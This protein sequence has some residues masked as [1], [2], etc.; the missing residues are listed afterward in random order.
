MKTLWSA[1][2]HGE[3]WSTTEFYFRLEELGRKDE[4]KKWIEVSLDEGEIFNWTAYDLGEMDVDDY[5]CGY[6]VF[7]LC[8][9]YVMGNY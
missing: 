2:F 9:A 8:E 5:M 3:N 4:I 7:A 6:S 1:L